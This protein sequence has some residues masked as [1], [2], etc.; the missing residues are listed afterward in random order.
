MS[1]FETPLLR[2]ARSFSPAFRGSERVR[3]REWERTMG[4]VIL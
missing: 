1:S 2:T 4:G 3:G